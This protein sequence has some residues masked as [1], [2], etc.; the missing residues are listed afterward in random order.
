MTRPVQYGMEWPATAYIQPAGSGPTIWIA[1]R[2]VGDTYRRVRNGSTGKM[3]PI[4]ST[5]SMVSATTRYHAWRGAF[6]REPGVVSSSYGSVMSC[7]SL[8][9]VH[10]PAA[11]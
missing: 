2:D 5:L 7:L 8:Q 10:C 3:M 4:P 1:A 9:R 11:R 6:V